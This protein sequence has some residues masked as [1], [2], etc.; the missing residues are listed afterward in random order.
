MRVKK[1]GGLY[2]KQLIAQLNGQLFCAFYLEMRAINL[3]KPQNVIFAHFFAMIFE[4]KKGRNPSKIKGF[5]HVLDE[6]VTEH[7][8]AENQMEWVQRMNSIRNRATEIV[9][10]ELIYV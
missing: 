5:R 8:K 4:I 3:N 7:L 9:N 1:Q 6:G 2:E 10:H